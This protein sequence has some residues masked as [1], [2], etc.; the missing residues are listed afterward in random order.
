MFLLVGAALALQIQINVGTPDC[1]G[2]RNVGIT[3]GGDA[4]TDSVCG[5]TPRRV[6]VT[7]QH[8]ATAFRDAG[9][10]SLLTNARVARLRRDSSIVSYEANAYQRLS[11]GLGFARIGRDRLIFRTENASHVRWH[12]DAGAWIEVKGA[13]TAFPIA[14]NGEK[15]AREDIADDLDEMTPLPYYPGYEPLWIGAGLAKA[16]VDEREL[17]H[18]LAEG[19]EAYYT[20]QT[21]D[22]ASVRLP[23]GRVIRIRELRVRP[24]VTRWNVAVGSLWFDADG[25]QL[26]RA[27][28]RLAEPIDVWAEVKRNNAKD[29]EEVPKWVKPLISPLHAQITAIAVEYGLHQGRFWLPRTHAA[30]GEA[31]MSAFRVPFKMEQSF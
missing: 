27:V 9:A 29:A 3:A 7:P 6:P 24:R 2:N 10:R 23:D 17:V 25:G 26:V 13:R 16:E 19:S 20:Y 4:R 31:R 30:E 21:G 11:A 18:P 22:T 28:Y 1:R 8:L 12:R 5:P 14:P 15:E